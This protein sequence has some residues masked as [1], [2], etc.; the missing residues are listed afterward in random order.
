MDTHAYQTEGNDYDS[1]SFQDLLAARDAY[2]VHL[3]NY[4]HVVATAV[5]R[6]RIRTADSWPGTNGKAKHKG[7]GT[8][9]VRN[10]ELRPYIWAAMIACVSVCR[11]VVEFVDKWGYDA[12]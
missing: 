6:Y 5:G 10:S 3:M 11:D 4:P 12:D 9:T 8:R 1:L 7:Y 2:H